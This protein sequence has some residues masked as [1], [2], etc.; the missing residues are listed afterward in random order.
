MRVPVRASDDEARGERAPQPEPALAPGL[1][2][3]RPL[4]GAYVL[5]CLERAPGAEGTARNCLAGVRE[6]RYAPS[7]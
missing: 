7:R 5:V 4:L 3:V 6:G 1:G 2:A